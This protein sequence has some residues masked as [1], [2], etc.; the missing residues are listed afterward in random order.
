MDKIHL[1]FRQ[2]KYQLVV[3]G[4]VTL[5]TGMTGTEKTRLI[6]LAVDGYRLLIA[7]YMGQLLFLKSDDS[8]KILFLLDEDNLTKTNAGV[9]NDVIERG[10]KFLVITKEIAP[11]LVYG[12][13]NILS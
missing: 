2:F 8:N 10:I 13:D 11:Y 12:V 3:L 4:N 7:D 5:L 1:E 9:Y 6:S